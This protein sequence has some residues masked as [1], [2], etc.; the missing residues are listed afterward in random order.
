MFELFKNYSAA[1]IVVQIC[2]VPIILLFK[3]WAARF[4]NYKFQ[5]VILTG[6][7]IIGIIVPGGLML[8][9]NDIRQIEAARLEVED[10]LASG[11]PV[12]SYN[13]IDRN[14]NELISEAKSSAIAIVKS[15]RDFFYAGF[16]RLLKAVF[17]VFWCGIITGLMLFIVKVKRHERLINKICISGLYSKKEVNGKEYRI[18]RSQNVPLPFTSGIIKPAIYLPAHMPANDESMVLLH[19]AFHVIKNHMLNIWLYELYASLLWFNPAAV[20]LKRQNIRLQELLTDAEVLS[21]Y[22]SASYAAVLIKYAE[23]PVTKKYNMNLAASAVSGKHFLE[24]IEQVIYN[25]N[26]IPSGAARSLLSAAVGLSAVL[27]IF[28]IPVFQT[29]AEE[30]DDVLP[31]LQQDMKSAGVAEIQEETAITERLTMIW[32]IKGGGR[33]TL[34]FGPAEPIPPF[35]EKAWVHYGIDIA[36]F[37]GT[38][39]LAAAGGIVTDAGYDEDSVGRYVIIRHTGGLYSVYSHLKEVGVGIEDEVSAGDVIGFLGSTGRSTGPHLHFAVS[40]S[41]VSEISYVSGRGFRNGTFEDPMSY[42]E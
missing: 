37:A 19:E 32:P 4:S 12:F 3:Y 34:P 42:F 26:C 41:A 2:L 17:P 14:E 11:H 8:P 5:R 33:M 30:T 7:F 28:F 24:R 6:I 21:E 18:C 25:R 1:F 9:A 22:D 20:F 38:E 39:V 10:D 15:R 35:Q 13:A 36:A 31:A 40:S 23:M 27:I 29:L 16:A